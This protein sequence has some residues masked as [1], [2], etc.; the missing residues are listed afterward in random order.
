MQLCF[1]SLFGTPRAVDWLVEGSRDLV[2]SRF[3]LFMLYLVWDYQLHTRVKGVVDLHTIPSTVADDPL[4]T[5]VA[6]C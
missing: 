2:T 4:Q 5:S 6:V 1:R 3:M